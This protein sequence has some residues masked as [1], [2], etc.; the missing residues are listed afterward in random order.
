MQCVR[1]V[2]RTALYVGQRLRGG[3]A[4][5]LALSLPKLRLY[6]SWLEKR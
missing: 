2:E 4:W 5:A 6:S 1:A 3:P